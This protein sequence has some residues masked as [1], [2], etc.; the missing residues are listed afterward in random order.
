VRENKRCGKTDVGDR[1]KTGCWKNPL[2]SFWDK[3]G[4]I[5]IFWE[6]ILMV[7]RDRKDTLRLN[8]L[9][10]T[11]GDNWYNDMSHILHTYLKF[12]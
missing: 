12:K 6:T 10:D 5:N 8:I 1:H 3:L 2:T 9:R 11:L 7:E 4:K